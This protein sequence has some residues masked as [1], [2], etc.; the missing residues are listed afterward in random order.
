[1]LSYEYKVRIDSLDSR[2]YTRVKASSFKEAALVFVEKYC[3]CLVSEVY[4][5][6]VSLLIKSADCPIEQHSDGNPLTYKEYKVSLK[7]VA[8]RV[9][10]NK[11]V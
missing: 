1:M 10:E 11:D 4:D 7:L 9:G 6:G 2:P 5:S 8:E 3:G